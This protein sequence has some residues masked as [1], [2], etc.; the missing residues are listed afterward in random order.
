MTGKKE[1]KS[2]GKS[3]A[4]SMMLKMMDDAVKEALDQLPESMDCQMAREVFLEG[5]KVGFAKAW[6]L[7]AVASVQEDLQQGMHDMA[8]VV[9]ENLNRKI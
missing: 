9:L 4:H 2:T 6:Q 3:K 7:A 5:Y 8:A 1:K